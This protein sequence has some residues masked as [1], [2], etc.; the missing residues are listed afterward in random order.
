MESRSLGLPLARTLALYIYL[1][2]A[3]D[4]ATYYLSVQ[5]Q[6]TLWLPEN[7]D[8]VFLTPKNY[9]LFF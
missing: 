8:R 7:Q 3:N 9:F 1:F 4:T 6:A 5:L 2:I